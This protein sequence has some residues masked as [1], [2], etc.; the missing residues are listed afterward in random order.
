[1][2]RFQEVC[3]C[4]PCTACSRKMMVGGASPGVGEDREED[5]SSILIR[6]RVTKHAAWMATAGFAEVDFGG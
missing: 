1:M 2:G 4:T 6:T 3:L 5:L